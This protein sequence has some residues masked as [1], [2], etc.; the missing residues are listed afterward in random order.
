ML[1]RTPYGHYPE[2][3]TSADNLDF[4]RPSALADSLL[5]Y[6][7][8]AEVLEDNR[9]C[10]NT[11]PRGEPQLGRRGLYRPIGG[12]ADPGTLQMAMLWVLNLSDGK[13]TLLDVSER[14]G[15]PFQTVS[16]AARILAR[17]NLLLKQDVS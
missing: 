3:H 13:H 17:H 12:A 2:Y 11:N 15:V 4:I 16:E 7:S 14:S 8:V 1:S 5:T 6:L 10:L 9:T